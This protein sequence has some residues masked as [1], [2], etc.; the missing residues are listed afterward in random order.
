ML[1]RIL[2]IRI[3][4]ILIVLFT[5]FASFSQEEKLLSSKPSP[6]SWSISYNI[7]PNINFENNIG[8]KY[9]M[10]VCYA[11]TESNEF[12][13]EFST[14]KIPINE[15]S[16]HSI[17]EYSIGPRF[18]PFKSKIFFAEGN[19]GAQISSK[20]KDYIDWYYSYYNPVYTS[21]RVSAAFYLSAGIGAK[22]FISRNN[23]FL[24]KIKY[25]T[26]MPYKDGVSYI[27]AQ[28][29]VD[30]NNTVS[31]KSA[32]I[33]DKKYSFS[34]GGGVN[35]PYDINSYSKSGEGILLIEG[36][37]ITG[38]K[39]EIFLEAS[40]NRFGYDYM[41]E[42]IESACLDFGPRFYINK[43]ELSSFMEFGG[44]INYL[45]YKTESR[46]DPIQPGISIGTGFTGKL[47]SLLAL[48]LKGKI[49]LLFTDNP[50][51]PPYSILAGGVRFN[52]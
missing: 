15:Y 48:F 12:I 31:N 46:Y 6:G 4:F 7:G 39:N 18:Y 28:I 52:L 50:S 41:P 16:H 29:G 49:H 22:L 20:S 45:F 3:S 38:E 40:Y 34:A 33:E 37:Y 5:S 42:Q 36:T 32:I 11:E 19:I 24:M 47:N 43:G 26:S 27:G 1:T 10:E 23:S 17:L 44:S 8:Y 35:S 25:N 9:S 2:F 30:F 14:A 51:Q 21:S 13:L